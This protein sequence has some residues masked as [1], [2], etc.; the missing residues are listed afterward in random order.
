MRVSIIHEVKIPVL[1]SC[2]YQSNSNPGK[3]AGIL[4]LKLGI[5]PAGGTGHLYGRVRNGISILRPV[6]SHVNFCDHGA[7]SKAPFFLNRKSWTISDFP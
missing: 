2:L 7:F 6:F 5:E 3:V 1:N 4:Y